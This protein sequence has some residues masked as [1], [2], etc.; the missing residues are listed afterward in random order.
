MRSVMEHSFSQVPRAEIPRSTFDRSH[1]LKT[2]FDADWLIP[3]YVDDVMPGDTFRM[4]ANFMGR[5]STPLHPIMDNMFLDTFFFFVPYR[6]VW[7]DFKKFHGERVDPDDSIDYTVPVMGAG[8]STM[9]VT[10]GSIFDYMG[11]PQ[12]N[13]LRTDVS[14]LPFRAYNLIWN[15]W[16]RDQNLQ[17]S[18]VVDTQSGN[19]NVSDYTLL[20]RGKRHDYFT[21]SLPSP[22]KGASVQ[23]PLGSTAPVTGLGVGSVNNNLIIHD[24]VVGVDRH[25][26]QGGSYVGFSATASDGKKLYADLSD[27]TA[28][29]INDLRLAFQ[30]QRL[31]ERDARGGTRYNELIRA[32]FGVTVPDFRVQRPEFIGG[33]SSMVN[34]TPIANTAGQAG[35]YVG[36]LG[37]M[38]TVSGSHDW[39][40]SA[41]EHGVIIGLA[42][43]RGDI[44]YSQGLERY[45]SKSTRYDF[46]YPVLAQI[47]EQAVLGKE[48]YY[49]TGGGNDDVFGYQER[50]A[51]YRYK[52]SRLTG[53]FSPWATGSLDSWHLSEEFA[54]RPTL[55]GTFIQSN[56]GAPLDRAIAVP[57]EPHFILDTYFNLK[58]VRPMPLYGVPGNLDHF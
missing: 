44:T 32:H 43:V 57:S 29:T 4:N 3:I 26:V 46:Y 37:A 16:F 11:L 28:A 6:L 36:Q 51:E 33:G 1:G 35:D 27:A 24:G 13:V 5:L 2:T 23:L 58:C 21:A 38:G 25:L 45:W 9:T 55:G 30:T 7:D 40:Y 12:T 31:L 56:T 20:K 42:N 8:A 54:T 17:D 34:V 53:L 19:S 49:S 50:Y 39:T 47:G 10:A 15:E 52:P 18:V 41:V 22:Q 14:A 48:I